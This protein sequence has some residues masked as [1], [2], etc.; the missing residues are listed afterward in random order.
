MVS[1]WTDDKIR[2]SVLSARQVAL[3]G[4]CQDLL[5]QFDRL[6]HVAAPH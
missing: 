5:R 6:K 2:S 3:P 1:G 4:I